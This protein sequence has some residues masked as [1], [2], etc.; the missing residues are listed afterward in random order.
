MEIEWKEGKTGRCRGKDYIHT[1]RVILGVG[2]IV[3]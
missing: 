1:V 2:D 3:D